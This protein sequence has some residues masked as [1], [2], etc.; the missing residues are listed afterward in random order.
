M[1]Q[2]KSHHY[3]PQM[4]MRLFAREGDN[5]I[6]V[7]VIDRYKFIPGAPIRG[8]ACRD[9]FYGKDGRTERALGYIEGHA[10]RIFGEIVRERRLPA[11]SSQNHE[12]LV[13]YLGMQHARTVG[14][15]E[16][17]NE[18]SEKVAKSILRTKAELEGNREIVEALDRVRIRRTNAVSELM[19]YKT[20]GANLLTDL[21]LVLI[22]NGS[23]VPFISSDT[24]VVFHNRHYEG[25]HISV[26]GYANVG[27]QLFLP[28]GPRL[29]L[30]GFDAAAYEVATDARD[31][32]LL[33]DPSEAALIND[34]QWEAAHAVMLTAPD[35]PEQLLQSSAAT[36]SEPRQRERSVFREGGASSNRI[37]RCAHGTDRARLRRQ[38]R[39]TFRSCAVS[40]PRPSRSARGTSRRFAMP[41]VSPVSTACSTTWMRWT[42]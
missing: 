12:W 26:T 15:A 28:L 6:G 27:L 5:R 38:S 42:N 25:Q 20:I 23:A 10:A 19:G 17:Y 39:S 9:Y 2:N 31:I 24:P 18:G 11:V 1:P 3:V 41:T 37:T 13:F 34:L 7:F 14:A 8:Q 36:W 16:Q 32:V 29:A 22:E 33:D 30:F 4:Y 35:M 40:C 21:K